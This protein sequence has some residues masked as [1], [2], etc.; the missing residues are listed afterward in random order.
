MERVE[1]V[2]TRA[3]SSDSAA[4]VFLALVDRVVDFGTS[5]FEDAVARVRE[6]F[7]SGSSNVL[8]TCDLQKNRWYNC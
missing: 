3:G 8:M 6:V 4:A 5:S 7:F 1:R 2:E